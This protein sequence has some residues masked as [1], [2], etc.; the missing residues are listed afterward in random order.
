[1]SRSFLLINGVIVVMWLPHRHK[2]C[3]NEHEHEES[4]RRYRNGHNDNH[5]FLFSHGQVQNLLPH[6]SN[7]HTTIKSNGDGFRR[8]FAG[9]I[10]SGC[11]N[12]EDTNEKERRGNKTP[13]N[14][15][16]S[17][18]S[19]SLPGENANAHTASTDNMGNRDEPNRTLC[20]HVWGKGRN[21]E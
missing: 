17:D 18:V 9:L 12:P 5:H 16:R 11:V 13:Y 4:H 3:V 2:D 19:P 20:T 8:S 6:R 14:S 15:R 10:P 1:M 21:G 7:S